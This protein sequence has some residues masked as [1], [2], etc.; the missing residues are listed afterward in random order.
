M[1]KKGVVFALLMIL[2]SYCFAREI[3]PFA[4]EQQEQQFQTLTSELRCLVCQNESLAA[5]DATLAVELRQQIYAKVKA[6]QTN[7]QIKHYMVARYGD[8]VLFKPPVNHRTYVLWFGPIILLL[9]AFLILI[10]AIRRQNK[11]SQS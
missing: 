11:A 8:F 9:V 10:M 7:A 6:G 3:Y 1:I 2:C 5:S 4:T